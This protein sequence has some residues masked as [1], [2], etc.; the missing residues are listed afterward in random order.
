MV[1]KKIIL[2]AI[3][4][5]VAITVSSFIDLKGLAQ[6]PTD[7]DLAVYHAPIH[8]QDTDSTKYNADYITR[9]DYDTDWLATNNWDNLDHF[10]LPS[11]A[12]HSVVETCTH[13][14]ITYTFFHPR[15]WSDIPFDQE[16]ENDSEGM[17]AIIR[18]DGSA[19]GKLEGIVTVFH[20]NFY[21][22]TPTGSPLTNGQ[23]DIDG[24][25]TMSSYNGSQHPLTTQ[26]AKGHGFKA[27]PY[28]G[29]FQGASN[30]DGIIYYP[31]S[32]T[33]ELPAS[34]NDRDVKYQLL[35]VFASNGMWQHQ[36][37]Q[38]S[39]SSSS[40]LTFASWG[41]FKGDQ[42]GGCGS[43]TKSCSTNS[44]NAAWGWDDSDDGSVYKGE[45]ALDPAHLTDVYFNGLGTF[46]S[47]YIR[48]KFIQDLRDRGYNSGNLPQ[49]WPSQI[50]LNSLIGKL[51]NQC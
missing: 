8:Y 21:S 36:L 24:T 29:D 39:Q 40:A 17:L 7:L 15:D 6:S 9:F 4:I 14:F 16:H 2:F 18:K 41:T 49:G 37:D 44:A 22:Y 33:A 34:G 43:G 38:A 35:D 23:E 46:D 26:E 10:S 20:N 11:H 50:N 42:S 32:T 45:M 27:W 1:F 25:L 47:T 19:F 13:W 28:A 5:F 48:N 30:Q 51:K 3:G 31:S 12:Y